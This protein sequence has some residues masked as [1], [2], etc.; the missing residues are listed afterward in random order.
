LAKDLATDFGAALRSLAAF[1]ATVVGL[2][3][4]LLAIA[5]TYPRH[6]IVCYYG[7]FKNKQKAHSTKAFR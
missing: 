7:W 3:G 6:P 4:V 1:L 2:M 5:N